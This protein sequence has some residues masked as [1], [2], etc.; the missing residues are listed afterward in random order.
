MNLSEATPDTLRLII[1]DAEMSIE[2]GAEEPVR[3][4]QMI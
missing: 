1:E 2:R 3:I 4:A